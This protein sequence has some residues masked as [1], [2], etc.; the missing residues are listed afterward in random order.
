MALRKT[1]QSSK[2]PTA[3]ARGTQAQAT[4]VSTKTPKKT[5]PKVAASSK[6]SQ[7]SEQPSVED[8]LSV[9]ENLLRNFRL[10]YKPTKK[11]EAIPLEL[12]LDDIL[13]RLKKL[14]SK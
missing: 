9:L 13:A 14:E 7:T 4:S 5:T 1:S 12:V 3:G 2:K 6:K 11:D 10:S 8:R